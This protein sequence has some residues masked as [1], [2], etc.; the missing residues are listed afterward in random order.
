MTR[1]EAIQ[2]AI[3]EVMDF[4]D[5]EKCI[6]VMKLLNWTWLNSPEP[7]DK[8]EFRKSLRNALRCAARY[9]GYASGGFNFT[10]HDSIDRETGEPFVMFKGGF[11]VEDVIGI[12]G[13]AYTNEKGENET[14][15]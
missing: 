10:F 7:P 2:E 9:G 11:Y 13:I 12:D 3:D 5:V 1:E 6:K 15:S 8:Y 4:F 14:L